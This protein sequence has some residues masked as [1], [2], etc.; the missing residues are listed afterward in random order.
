MSSVTSPTE[1]YDEVKQY[2]VVPAL[3]S[4]VHITPEKFQSMYKKSI[5]DPESFFGENA[6]SFLKWQRPFNKVTQGS[7]LN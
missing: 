7:F 3:Q 5:E 4:G 1:Q 2:D 6:K